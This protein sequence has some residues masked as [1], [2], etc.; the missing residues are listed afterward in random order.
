V[1]AVDVFRVITYAGQSVDR[2]LVVRKNDANRCAR[3]NVGVTI[4]SATG[5]QYV[6]ALGS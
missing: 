3:A 2:D 5:T 4:M 6:V 1:P